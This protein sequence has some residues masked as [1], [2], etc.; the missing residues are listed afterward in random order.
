MQQLSALD[1]IVITNFP[2]RHKLLNKRPEL[3]TK[4]TKKKKKGLQRYLKIE[5]H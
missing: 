4:W 2:D 1:K 5:N 3:K